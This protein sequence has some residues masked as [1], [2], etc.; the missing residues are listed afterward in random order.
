MALPSNCFG[1]AVVGACTVN[2]MVRYLYLLFT[3][4]CGLVLPAAALAIHSQLLVRTGT[5]PATPYCEYT[6]DISS[7]SFAFPPFACRT[8][9]LL[10]GFDH[11]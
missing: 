7:Y 1:A 11:R 9:P 4:S 2:T 6:I 3:V 8:E 10:G 5:A